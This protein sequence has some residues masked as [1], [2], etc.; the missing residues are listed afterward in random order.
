MRIDHPVSI[1]VKWDKANSL[2]EIETL[3]ADIEKRL[4][5]A[6]HEALLIKAVEETSMVPRTLTFKGT[7]SI[8]GP[9]LEDH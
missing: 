1:E 3:Y 7:F 2:K 4:Q 9:S 8:T 6:L 5:D